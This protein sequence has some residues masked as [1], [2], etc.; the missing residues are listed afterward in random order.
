MPRWP[1]SDDVRT[2]MRAWGRQQ[3]AVWN[4]TQRLFTEMDLTMAQFRALSVLRG[5]DRLTGK[6]LAARL[7]I[8]PATL[9]PLVDRLEAQGYVRR[10]PDLDDRRLTWIELTKKSYRLFLRLWIGG[11]ARMLQAIRRLSPDDRREL[12]RL[13]NQVADQ[14]A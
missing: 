14:L 3:A 4:E 13:L 12:A 2:A 9:I 5:S 1:G 10:V 6:D 8:T 11:Q 7:H